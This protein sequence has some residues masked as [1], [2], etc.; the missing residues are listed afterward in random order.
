MCQTRRHTRRQMPRLKSSF[1]RSSAVLLA[2]LLA[3]ACKTGTST[4]STPRCTDADAGT[5]RV[6]NQSGRMVEIHVWRATSPRMF[7]GNA[8]PGMTTFR[9]EGP[10]DLA[11]RYTAL[12]PTRGTT[13]ATVSWLRPHARGGSSQ[14]LLDLTCVSTR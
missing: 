14:V 6:T 3:A 7:V 9:V 13:Y 2:M 4:A 5:L 8:S 12:D 1:A 11:V 10:S